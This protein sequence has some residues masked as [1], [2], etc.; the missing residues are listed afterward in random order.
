MFWNE[1][2][3]KK[4]STSL[5]SLQRIFQWISSRNNFSLSFIKTSCALFSVYA[6]FKTMTLNLILKFMLDFERFLK[7]VE[8]I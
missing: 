1:L 3:H 7:L 8:E 5:L 4:V 2:E 6:V